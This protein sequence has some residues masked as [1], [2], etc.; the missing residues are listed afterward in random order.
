MWWNH[1]K[2]LIALDDKSSTFE[3]FG[4]ISGLKTGEGAVFCPLALGTRDLAEGK[5]I[6][7]FGRGCLVIKVR[8]KLTARTGESIL[9][10]R[11]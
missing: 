8:R 5:R 7:K 4:L 2:R 3:G 9:S 6:C 1:L 10:Q 11:V